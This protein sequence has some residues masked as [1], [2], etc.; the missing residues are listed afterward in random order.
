[1]TSRDYVALIL[2]LYSIYSE[3]DFPVTDELIDEFNEDILNE[4]ILEDIYLNEL[5]EVRFNGMDIGV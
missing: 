4:H 1:M 2:F 3:E 5:K